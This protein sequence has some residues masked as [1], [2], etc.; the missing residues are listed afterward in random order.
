MIWIKG[1]LN[2]SGV[3]CISAVDLTLIGLE[4]MWLTV[5]DEPQG[6]EAVC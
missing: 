3:P 2:I 4:T 1:L 6:H 5:D